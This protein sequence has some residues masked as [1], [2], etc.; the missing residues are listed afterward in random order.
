MSVCLYRFMIILSMTFL[1]GACS[2]SKKTDEKTDEIPASTE[3]PADGPLDAGTD[4]VPQVKAENSAIASLEQPPAPL[5]SSTP[6]PPTMEANEK[7]H[8]ATAPSLD[9][10]AH[11]TTTATTTAS[12]TD[13]ATNSE[14]S[15]E[16]ENYTMQDG[17][18]L[19]KIAYETYG[20]IYK[21]KDIYE[22]NKDKV[23]DPNKVP[24]GTVLKV[25]KPSN[26]VAI[27]RNGEKYLIQKGDTLGKISNSVYGTES[28]WKKIWDNNKQLIHDPNKIFAG[29][30][31]Y[32]LTDES[33]KA[34]AENLI[35]PR[36]PAA[37]SN[38]PQSNVSDQT[39]Q[40]T[41]PS[42]T[43]TNLN[44]N[45]DALSNSVNALNAPPNLGEPPRP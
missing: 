45:V 14:M 41:L 31:L 26:A 7:A 35:S 11:S 12:A 1:L 29:F 19:M 25:N 10:S 30:Y 40:T 21:W 17:D 32:Y 36:V 2:H 39:R 34:P 15:G 18:T 3:L 23:P 13:S 28:K 43:N 42:H 38:T 24:K 8:E 20:D 9:S 16:V 44:G 22:A 5:A 33:K 27:N 6:P 4:A 37:Q